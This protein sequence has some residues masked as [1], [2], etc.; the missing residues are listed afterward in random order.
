MSFLSQ[1]KTF[2]L[3]NTY[4]NGFLDCSGDILLRSGNVI[5]GNIL[6]PGYNA[7]QRSLMVNGRTE[8]NGNVIVNGNLLI[9]SNNIALGLK[10]ANITNGIQDGLPNGVNTTAVGSFSGMNHTGQNNTFIGSVAGQS[11]STTYDVRTGSNNTYIGYRTSANNSAWANSTAVGTGAVISA[12]NQIVLGTASETISI[13]GP[14]SIT[15]NTTSTNRTN[16]SL[17]VTGG[18]GVDNTINCRS[19]NCE[20]IYSTYGIGTNDS[21]VSEA[22][23]YNTGYLRI[24]SSD[25]ANY[26]QSGLSYMPDSVAPL[27]FTSVYNG[28]EAMR[29][30]VAN[31]RL[32]IGTE[33]PTQMLGI[34]NSMRVNQAQATN[35]KLLVLWD[36]NT[37]DQV[38]TATAF[39]GFGVNNSTLRYQVDLN[40]STHAF[41]GG[42]TQY[43]RINNNT[44][45]FQIGSDRK[46]KKNITELDYGLNEI[47]QLKPS[48]Y[49]M[50]EE[51]EGDPTHIGLI[52]QDVQAILPEVVHECLEDDN[53]T[54][55]MLSHI[56]FIPVLIRAIQ[57]QQQQIQNLEERLKTLENSR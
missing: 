8:M 3:R 39:Y 33:T 26:I 31:K 17:V 52:A 12:S 23:T 42:A 25:S 44:S 6:Q 30:D 7:N 46:L 24:I 37:N 43:G 49:L 32:G 16:G 9:S 50:K 5:I 47:L 22:P 53:T 29:L 19:I 18:L 2:K 48:R 55:L 13:A 28:R 14:V 1:P 45:G 41:W 54:T 36:A 27:I 10:S 40:G 51:N 34:E 11:S 56:G 35:N 4:I 57:Q 15:N 21:F 20:G 38:A